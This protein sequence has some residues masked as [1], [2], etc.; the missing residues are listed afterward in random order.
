MKVKS[1]LKRVLHI[2]IG[3]LIIAAFFALSWAITIGLVK[4]ITLCF[5][6]QFKLSTATG[7]WLILLIVG[8]LIPKKS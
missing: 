4:L 3:I 8:S 7:I 6:W 2:L 1:L 5:E